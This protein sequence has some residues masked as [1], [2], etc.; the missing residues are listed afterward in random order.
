MFDTEQTKIDLKEQA[1]WLQREHQKI[2]ERIQQRIIALQREQ[3]VMG[4]RLNMLTTID[5]HLS[6]ILDKL[7]DTEL[8]QR[9]TKSMLDTLENVIHEIDTTVI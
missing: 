5:H 2:R 1:E 4:A 7:P 9:L 3:Y 6:N 8:N